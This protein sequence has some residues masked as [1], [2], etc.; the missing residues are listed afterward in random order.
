M[1]IT[2]ELPKVDEQYRM[3]IDDYQKLAGEFPHQLY[4]QLDKLMLA[5]DAIRCPCGDTI[6][7]ADEIEDGRC[8]ECARQ[9]LRCDDLG[10]LMVEEKEMFC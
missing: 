4:E 1:K 7:T 5:A 8:A 2:L 3:T 10:I 9:G 6:G